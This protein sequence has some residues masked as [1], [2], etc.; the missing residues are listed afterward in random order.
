MAGQ[1]A[2][3][4][5]PEVSIAADCRHYWVIEAPTGPV[6]RGSCRSCGESREFKNYIDSS[7][8]AA[9]E[10]PAYPPGGGPPQ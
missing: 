3:P 2:E 1:I 9:A 10:E 5:V 7:T 8:S 4:Q 6:S